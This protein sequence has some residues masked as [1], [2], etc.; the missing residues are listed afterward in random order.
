MARTLQHVSIGSP[1][2]RSK[3]KPR[4]KPY[5][6]ELEPG[7]HLGYRKP[8]NGAGAWVLRA[9]QGDGHYKREVIGTADDL[10]NARDADGISLL[11]WRHA[12]DRAREIV[13]ARLEAGVR[14]TIYTVAM[15]AEDYLA[16]FATARKSIADARGR[17]AA[18][19]LPAL[20]ERPVAE[21]TADELRTWHANLSN[22]AARVRTA[23]GKPQ[24]FKKVANDDE[25]KRRRRTSSNRTLTTLK[26][27]LNRAWSEGKV[28]SD[29]AWRRV[30]PFH[31]VTSSRVRYLTVAEA[32]RLINATSGEFRDLVEGA[33]ATGCRYGE[34]GRMTCADF[35][36]DAG[37][38]AVRTSKSGKPRHVVLTHEG[39][40]LFSRLTLG[41][42]GD[43]LIFGVWGPSQQARPMAEA[44]KGASLS[45]P[46]TFH[47]L[48]H[49][50]ASL[51]VMNGLPLMIVARNLGH[52]DT[53]M[54]E[55][56]YGH[57]APSY[58]ADAI[59]AGAP[60]FNIS[61]QSN[62][63]DLRKHR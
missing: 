52:A 2:S 7:L 40:A 54:V 25:A 34:L 44:C 6:A 48:R 9:Y 18:H 3:L 23:K 26:A 35:N 17:I 62:I 47:G 58:I 45:P 16:W 31:G 19:I 51:A 4:G 43:D 30:K 1:T 5:F 53:R 12:Q 36:I 28:Q 60:Q 27:L 56:H 42:A 41:R 57:M 8:K 49:T 46:I 38:V 37:T 39:A 59:R 10:V 15:A 22:S 14:G 63:T 32:R 61:A 33:L 21:L 24:K 29:D 11:S 55:R 50:W 13:A 20:G